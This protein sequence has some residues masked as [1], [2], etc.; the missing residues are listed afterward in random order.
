MVSRL[1]LDTWAFLLMLHIH[2]NSS[3]SL[4]YCSMDILDK[5]ITSFLQNIH[6]WLG[7]GKNEYFGIL[8]W[9]C[10]P[11]N[12][13]TISSRESAASSFTSIIA[14][15]RSCWRDFEIEEC[16]NI[17]WVVDALQL[18]KYCLT[19]HWRHTLIGLIKSGLL[20]CSGQ[21]LKLMSQFAQT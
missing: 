21:C 18:L 4:P 1:S 12:C 7:K 15:V 2:N 19:L 10:S 8:F 5:N 6:H 11:V 13:P 14:A 3:C 16:I 20:P 9:L 17:W